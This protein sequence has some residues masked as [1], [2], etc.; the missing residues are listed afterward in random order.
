MLQILG[1]GCQGVNFLWDF[2]G[3]FEVVGTG[4]VLKLGLDIAGKIW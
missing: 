3:F 2:G 4:T 1:G